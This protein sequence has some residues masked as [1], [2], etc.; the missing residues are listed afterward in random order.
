MRSTIAAAFIALPGFAA[1]CPVCA[2]DGGSGAALLVGALIL[3]PYAVA[4]VVIRAI[5]RG[6]D[7]KA[8]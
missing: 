7:G 6:E 5:R 8:R 3:A 2:R 4:A 1:A